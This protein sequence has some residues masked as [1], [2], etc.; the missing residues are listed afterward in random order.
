MKLGASNVS[1]LKGGQIRL[2]LQEG[3]VF[4][5][6]AESI[7]L[8]HPD[9]N[10][11]AVTLS[12]HLHLSSF[13]QE[14]LL[15]WAIKNESI[16]GIAKLVRNPALVGS[17][18]EKILETGLG[19]PQI[20]NEAALMLLLRK[21]IS[22][23]LVRQIVKEGSR[24]MVKAL[25][26]SA[27][28]AT[29]DILRLAYHQRPD[30]L[31]DVLSNPSLPRDLISEVILN[32]EPDKLALLSSN[33]ALI[34]EDH[35]RLLECPQA[36]DGL[37]RNLETS[38][39]IRK[40]LLASDDGVIVG[41]IAYNIDLDEEA[42]RQVLSK[43]QKSLSLIAAIQT[44]SSVII[45]EMVR[46]GYGAEVQEEVCENELL[47]AS[48]ISLPIDS[49]GPSGLKSLARH[50]N[51]KP[52]HHDAIMQNGYWKVWSMIEE[53]E[54]FAL[55]STYPAKYFY[56]SRQ[57]ASLKFYRT[58]GIPEDIWQAFGGIWEGSLEEL[59]LVG[60]VF[61]VEN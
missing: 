10:V 28:L 38:M 22:P 6:E 19:C 57:E 35:F 18:P 44:T 52:E 49:V 58:V 14:E 31:E 26:R 46:G 50:R 55:K 34:E 21:N 39:A 47:N 43:N 37:S 36:W 29:S 8:K 60:E 5:Q 27:H 54:G 4:S 2:L 20:F 45:E 7:L 12:G 32:F 3:Y 56:Y 51:L 61:S 48:H 24:L 30:V 33:P 1:D 17:M 13:A 15:G 41:R 59:Q 42:S 23:Q 40:K 11:F 53:R 9:L 16:P 25:L